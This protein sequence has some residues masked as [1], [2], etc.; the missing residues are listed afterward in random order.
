MKRHF[1]LDVLYDKV[2]CPSLGLSASFFGLLA[3][4]AFGDK[5]TPTY[6]E[7]GVLIRE[8]SVCLQ[9]MLAYENECLKAIFKLLYSA[10]YMLGTI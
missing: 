10:V 4:S 7:I 8:F 3:L 1:C 9:I 2:C 6:S 5:F